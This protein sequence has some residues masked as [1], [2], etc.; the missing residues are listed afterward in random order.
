MT[1][2]TKTIGDAELRL[3]G[4][5]ALNKALGPAKTFR[6]L[7]LF[8]HEPSDLVQISRRHYENQSTEE[9]FNRGEGQWRG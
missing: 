1:K 8:Q 5:D 3:V 7:A 2:R 9:I 4:M 6:F